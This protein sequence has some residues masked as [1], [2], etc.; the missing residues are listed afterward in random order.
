MEPGGCIQDVSRTPLPLSFLSCNDSCYLHLVYAIRLILTFRTIRPLL[1]ACETETQI[2]EYSRLLDLKI[3]LL[4]FEQLSHPD[5]LALTI[6]ETIQVNFERN[7]PLK[8]R[9]SQGTSWWNSEC[10]EK[11]AAY[12]RARKRGEATTEK[13]ALRKATRAAKKAHWQNLIQKARSSTVIFRITDWYKSRGTYSSPPIVHEGQEYTHP[14]E[15][16][17]VLRKALLERRTLEDDLFD[18]PEMSDQRAH[19]EVQDKVDE[20]EIEQCIMHSSNTAPGM[21]GI[22]V[23]ILRAFWGVIKDAMCALFQRCLT[24]GHHPRV[25]Q[26]AEIV[27]L[28]KPKKETSAL[29]GLGDR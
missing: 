23:S 11:A 12:R 29:S 17:S 1:K 22:S 21:D 9:I 19:L 6:I 26:R 8:R 2:A 10:R 25:F 13:Q 14:E 24:L 3:L 15:K 16:I 7:L 27:L 18:E 5:I 4:D 20:S 28:P